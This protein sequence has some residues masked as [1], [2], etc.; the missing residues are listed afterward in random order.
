MDVQSNGALIA[1]IPAPSVAV[2]SAD[3]VRSRRLVAALPGTP[4]VSLATTV[5]ELVEHAEGNGAPD[6]VAVAASAVD[7][8]V[9]AVRELREALPASRVV[10]VL[11][12]PRGVRRM[13][14]AGADGV[15]LERDLEDALRVTVDAVHAGQIAV[16]RELKAHVQ[17]D[18]LSF[19]ER[20]ILGLVV[21]GFTN[22]E[23]ATQLCLAESTIKSHL[24]TAFGKL[25]VRSR[26]EA[27]AL[28]LDPDEGLGTGILAISGPGHALAGGGAS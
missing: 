27:A 13:L 22:C 3:E 19:R 25:G 17:S 28:I 5:A 12:E 20:Q 14:K 8:C 7:R 10:A 1:A 26:K 15:V 21:L 9:A 24:S 2:V 11:S 6:V 23:I 4:P 18:P 16:A